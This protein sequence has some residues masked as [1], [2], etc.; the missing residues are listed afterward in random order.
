MS[1][2]GKGDTPR[3]Y[4]V[5]PKTFENNWDAIFG[6]KKKSNEEKFDDKVIMQ[7]EFFEG[8]VK[9]SDQGG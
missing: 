5:D 7:D 1:H 3:P 2:G 8:T 9:D 6:K 4:S